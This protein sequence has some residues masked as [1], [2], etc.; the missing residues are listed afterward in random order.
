MRREVII[1]FF[2]VLILAGGIFGQDWRQKTEGPWMHATA[3]SVGLFWPFFEGYVHGLT[4]TNEQPIG[5][6]L[7][8]K[9]GQDN[10]H[11][12]YIGHRSAVLGS[13]VSLAMWHPSVKYFFTARGAARTVGVWCV[14][15][16]VFNATVRK[17]QTDQY[18]PKN[19]KIHGYNLEIA[20]LRMHFQEPHAWVRQAQ[21]GAGLALY[22]LPDIIDLI[23]GEK[24]NKPA[25]DL[26]AEKN[27]FAMNFSPEINFGKGEKFYGGVLVLKF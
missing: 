10:K 4:F 11:A 24:K 25:P 27:L 3:L 16:A 5:Y 23:K 17:V 1:V 18:F 13:A 26:L 9:V 2:V 15:T 22:F 8:I 12:L 21:L 14:W 6:P 7:G 19:N 20:G